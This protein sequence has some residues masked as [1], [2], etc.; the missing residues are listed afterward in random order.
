ML[1]KCDKCGNA[2]NVD[3]S[4]LSP[5]GARIKCPS[6]GNVFT[7]H[8]DGR[9]S[10]AVDKPNFNQISQATTADS[11]TPQKQV[12]TSS[13]EEPE[14]VWK[15]QHIGLT[16]TFHD[17]DSLRNWLSSRSTLDGVK[18][19]KDEEDWREIGDH[20]E[21]LTTEL[22][23]RFFP[24]GDIPTSSSVNAGS[25]NTAT[26]SLRSPSFVGQQASP[27][28]VT[29][30]LSGSDDDA[31]LK[32]S[33]KAQKERLRE[34]KLQKENTKKWIKIGV[35]V[36]VLV[37]AALVVFRS[38]NTSSTP[39]NAA[40][41]LNA[42]TAPI[43]Q[44]QPQDTAPQKAMPNENKQEAKTAATPEKTNPDAA[45]EVGMDMDDDIESLAELELQKQ[46]AEAEDMVDQKLWP[47]A[48]S[49]LEQLRKDMPNHIDVLKLLSKTYRGLSLDA[50]ADEIDAQVKK[51][52]RETL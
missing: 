36:V 20:K 13:N 1:V 9:I 37:V 17:L 22:I 31:T 52:Q 45:E 33:R 10:Q 41:N 48:R 39:G 18:I 27:L 12:N 34:Q 30:N 16:Y 50:K 23:T 47:E 3:D 40:A 29:M 26:S 6:C 43:A 7:V 2:Y 19:A 38:L 14:T 24:L 4:R 5:K 32:K 46:L 15:I 28:G 21:V 49:I 51:L 35:L 25:S 8:A 42:Q 44:E 11:S